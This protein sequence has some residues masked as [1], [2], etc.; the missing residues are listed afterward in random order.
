MAAAAR[1]LMQYYE[2]VR[3]TFSIGNGASRPGIDGI[4]AAHSSSNLK[5]TYPN[6]GSCT[7]L[8][9]SIGGAGHDLQWH[10]DVIDK[11]VQSNSLASLYWHHIQEGGDMTVSDFTDLI[12]YAI[13]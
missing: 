10:K 3:L 1:F 11:A 8:L 6:I 7:R 5:Y 13:D 4:I 12:D 2:V 9:Y